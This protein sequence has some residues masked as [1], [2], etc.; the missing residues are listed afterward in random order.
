ME[1]QAVDQDPFGLDK[2]VSEAKGIANLVVRA[3]LKAS[4][5]KMEIAMELLEISE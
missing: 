2:I 3:I 5:S 1:R 4:A